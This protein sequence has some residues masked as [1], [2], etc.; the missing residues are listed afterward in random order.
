[1]HVPEQV[2]AASRPLVAG[3]LDRKLPPPRLHSVSTVRP[4]VRPRRPGLEGK[5]PPWSASTAAAVGSQPDV[6]VGSA[7]GPGGAQ[8]SKQVPG[9]ILRITAVHVSH[10]WFTNCRM[11]PRRSSQGTCSL[12]PCTLGS[13]HQQQPQ[14][15]RPVNSSGTYEGGKV[16]WR[17]KGLWRFSGRI[18]YSYRIRPGQ[19]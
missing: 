12:P 8:A 6:R 16:A 17:I 15:V 4:C 14:I 3:R 10:G 19:I 1:M 2:S 7:D 9:P 11:D 18:I 5:S 13:R